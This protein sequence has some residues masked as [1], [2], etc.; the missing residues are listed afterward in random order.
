MKNKNI[1]EAKNEKNPS[2][3]GLFFFYFKE[4][5][6][7]PS[8]EQLLQK[9][10]DK[11]GD[12]DIVSDSEAVKMFSISDYLVRYENNQEVPAQLIITNFNEINQE[13]IT[14]QIKTQFWNFPDFQ[15]V[16][17]ACHWQIMISDFMAYGLHPH[18]RAELLSKWI[19]ITLDLFPTCQA[20]Y[21]APSENLLSAEKARNNPYEGHFRY[22]HGGLNCRYFRIQD[23][24]D[25]LVDSLGLHLLPLPDVQYHFHS[26]NPSD[27]VKHAYNI[28]YYQY[29]KEASIASGHTVQGLSEDQKWV[30]QYENSLLQPTRVLLDVNT[31]EY[32]SGSRG[33]EAET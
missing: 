11:L 29:E 13:L 17:D 18:K 33:T 3:I 25:M 21:Y 14:P 31:G 20:V 10:K 8:T 30:C 4:K 19:D 23:S 15:P 5:A 26:L 2:T 16:L 1:E 24:D 27:I 7:F 22:L 9:M 28:A 32:A 12:I 6:P